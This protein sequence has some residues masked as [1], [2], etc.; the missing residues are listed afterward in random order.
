M[1]FSEGPKERLYLP[2]DPAPDAPCVA[3]QA[4]DENSLYSEV[5]RLI[6]LRHAHEVLQADAD[7]E[8]LRAEAV[9][10]F[11]YRRGNLILAINP[12]PE[13]AKWSSDLLNGRYVIHAINGAVAANGQLL[14]PSRSFAAAGYR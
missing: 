2:Q 3:D 13:A 6:A 12:S 7:F 10:P 14:L 9:P 5:R 1:G 8:V 11:V 4:N